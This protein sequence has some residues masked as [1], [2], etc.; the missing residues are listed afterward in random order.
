MKTHIVVAESDVIDYILSS[1]VLLP[2]EKSSKTKFIHAQ[3]GDL[4][5][6]HTPETYDEFVFA[7]YRY[8]APEHRILSDLIQ[9]RPL[10]YVYPKLGLNP[11]NHR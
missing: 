9:Y 5:I 6:F 8:A 4:W 1:P 2:L 11:K 7:D 3:S 10:Y